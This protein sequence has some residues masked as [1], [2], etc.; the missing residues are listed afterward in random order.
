MGEDMVSIPM[1]IYG[2]ARLT[3]LCL[4]ADCDQKVDG[5]PASP[6]RAPC[7]AFGD[8]SVVSRV[9]PGSAPLVQPY[10]LVI[11]SRFLIE[12]SLEKRE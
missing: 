12:V 10:V 8:K 1:S 4:S 5:P 6:S 11:S 2:G 3:L 9:L 7:P